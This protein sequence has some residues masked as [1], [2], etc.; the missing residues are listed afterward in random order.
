MGQINYLE[1]IKAYIATSIDV[2]EM[3]YVQQIAYSMYVKSNKPYEI[4]YGG[5]PHNY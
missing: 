3:V 2:H 4:L 1:Y 5:I